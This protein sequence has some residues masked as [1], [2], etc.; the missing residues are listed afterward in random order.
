MLVGSV[1]PPVSKFCSVSAIVSDAFAIHLSA[2]RFVRNSSTPR[3]WVSKPPRCW[4]T[5]KP[6]RGPAGS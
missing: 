2:N 1:N 5:R 6:A 4:Y 3:Y